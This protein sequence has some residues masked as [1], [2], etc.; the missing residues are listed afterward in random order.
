MLTEMKRELSFHSNVKLIYYDA[1][2]NNEKQISQVKEIL[3]SD[4][5]LLI[6]SPNE[7]EPLT[8]IVDEVFQ[9]GIPVVVTDRKTSSG[10]YN[11]YVGA[12]NYDIG[13]LAGI[14]LAHQLN[15]KGI[16][17]EITG[18]SGSSAS[19]E[20]QNGFYSALKKYPGI[21][22]TQ[23]INGQWL[24]D[25]AR[26][27]VIENID[28]LRETDAIFAFNDQM[29]LGSYQALKAMELEHIKIVGVDALAGKNNGLEQVAARVIDASMFYPTGGKEAIRTALAILKKQ[30]Y[31]RENIL[32]TMVID[33]TNVQL[34]QMQANRINNQQED[35]DKQSALLAE[36]KAI[37]RDQQTILNI[38]VISLVLAIILGGISFYLLKYNWE[39]NKSL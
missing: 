36:Q 31:P 37:Y 11:A 3:E 18:L 34:M 39:K 8:K 16:V 9:K 29:A 7:A 20:R 4:I 27:E 17:T 26:K 38:L 21:L 33:S 19:I 32:Q 28:V 25:T 2:G 6:I 15:G 14:Y 13:H 5:D 23:P 30:A 10:L 35:I 24:I 1:E 22:A 12:N